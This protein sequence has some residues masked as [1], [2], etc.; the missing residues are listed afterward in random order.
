MPQPSIATALLAR[1]Y[2]R[3]DVAKVMGNNVRRMLGATIG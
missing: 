3:A 2:A 1:G